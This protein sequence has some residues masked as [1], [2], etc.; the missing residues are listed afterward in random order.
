[1]SNLDRKRQG[2]K[3]RR[4]SVAI[5]QILKGV[6]DNLTTDFD[7]CWR[8]GANVNVHSDWKSLYDKLSFTVA[9][10]A[11]LSI[12]FGQFAQSVC[13]GQSAAGSIDLAK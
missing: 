5:A 10:P 2:G 1:L 13:T 4:K 3:V 11:S 8:G 12:G 9:L 6:E 7:V